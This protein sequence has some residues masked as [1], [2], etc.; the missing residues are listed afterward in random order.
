[1]KPKKF[2]YYD[3]NGKWFSSSNGLDIDSHKKRFGDDVTFSVDGLS[4]KFNSL[5]EYKK[6]LKD[7]QVVFSTK[8][9]EEKEKEI[10]DAKVRVKEKRKNRIK[11]FEDFKS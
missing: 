5:A 10:A 8:T 9:E 6:A 7:N 2:S 11:T 3:K 1:M 4:G